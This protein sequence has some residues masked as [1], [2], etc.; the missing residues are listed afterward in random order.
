MKR[1]NDLESLQKGVVGSKIHS[2]FMKST[3]SRVFSPKSRYRN[4]RGKSRRHIVLG[5]AHKPLERG[6]RI[7]KQIEGRSQNGSIDL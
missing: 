6:S 4:K 3:D 5:S 2:T 7:E 1:I